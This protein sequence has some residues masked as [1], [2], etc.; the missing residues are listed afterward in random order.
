MLRGEDWGSG[1]TPVGG[2]SASP[3]GQ[4][5]SPSRRPLTRPLAPTGGHDH[6]VLGRD[7]VF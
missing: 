4:P 7:E 3:N 2:A 5:V 6:V 1:L